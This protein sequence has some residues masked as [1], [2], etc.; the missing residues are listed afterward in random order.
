MP[1][2][3]EKGHSVAQKALVLVAHL[4]QLDNFRA[5]ATYDQV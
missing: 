5:I 1:D 3:A 4:V 2:G